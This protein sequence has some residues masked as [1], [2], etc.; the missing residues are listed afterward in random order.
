MD[1]TGRLLLA[2]FTAMVAATA[3]P[4]RRPG[5]PGFTLFEVSVLLEDKG[6]NDV[7]NCT[8]RT[9]AG[10]YQVVC[11]LSRD[12]DRDL[13]SVYEDVPGAAFVGGAARL[14]FA[15]GDG[16]DLFTAADDATA[17][18]RVAVTRSTLWVPQATWPEVEADAVPFALDAL[19]ALDVSWRSRRSR[20]AARRNTAGCRRDG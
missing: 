15:T 12:T 20:R 7:A 10:P 4:L 1:C 9:P 16:N 5:D 8:W 11:E 18:A 13:I 6:S 3:C 17:R 14:D 2:T 19:D